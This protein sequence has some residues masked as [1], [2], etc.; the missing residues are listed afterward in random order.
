MISRAVV[1]LPQPVSPTRP[2]GLSA[3]D[4]KAHV[5]D[6]LHRADLALDDDARC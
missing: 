3:L 6:G 5:V 4:L 1:L 2:E